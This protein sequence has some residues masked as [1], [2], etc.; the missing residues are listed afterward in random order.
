M[1]TSAINGV[2]NSSTAQ[3]QSTSGTTLDKN[4]FLQLLT[5]QLQHQDPLQPT[6][7]TQFIAQLAQFSSLEQMTNVN[8]QLGTLNQTESLQQAA[9]LIGKTVTYTGTDGT[10]GVSGVVQSAQLQNGNLLLTVGGQQIAMSSINSIS[11]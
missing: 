1:S 11:Q 10:T 3:T 7:D 8:T 6:D 2:S 5:T 4:A 9:G